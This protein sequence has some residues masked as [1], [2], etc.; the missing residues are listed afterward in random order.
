MKSGLE[1]SGLA[2]SALPHVRINEPPRTWPAR[3]GNYIFGM[4]S[5][6]F[7]RLT[8]LPSGAPRSIDPWIV[9]NNFSIDSYISY[10]LKMILER[11]GKSLGRAIFRN[12]F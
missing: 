4:V 10:L 6:S 5:F 8:I 11:S 7:G 3:F 12:E 1:T 9:C 2:A